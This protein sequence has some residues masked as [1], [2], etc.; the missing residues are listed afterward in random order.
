[1]SCA[2]GECNR[3]GVPKCN[4]VRFPK[5]AAGGF[6]KT[7]SWIHMGH[8]PRKMGSHLSSSTWSFVGSPGLGGPRNHQPTVSYWGWL[9]MAGSVQDSHTLYEGNRSTQELLTLWWIEHGKEESHHHQEGMFRL[10]VLI[11]WGSL[12]TTYFFVFWMGSV[13]NLSTKVL[14]GASLGFMAVTNVFRKSLPRSPAQVH[15]LWMDHDG[16]S[17]NS[18]N[19]LAIMNRYLINHSMPRSLLL[20]VKHSLTSKPWVK[21]G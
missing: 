16:W 5:V 19:G 3:A 6:T 1:M 7:I 4:R 15:S 9:F 12:K 17:Y 14:Q 8:S 13:H 2:Q 20:M 10:A 18:T 21:N 11:V